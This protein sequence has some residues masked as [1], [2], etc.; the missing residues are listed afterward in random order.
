MS[1]A[2]SSSSIALPSPVAVTDRGCGRKIEEMFDLKL[3]DRV[4]SSLGESLAANQPL[5]FKVDGVKG[6]RFATHCFIHSKSVIGMG[7]VKK[8]TVAYDVKNNRLTS[9]VRMKLGKSA[10]T[11]KIIGKIVQKERNMMHLNPTGHPGIVQTYAIFQSKHKIDIYQELF[12][13]DLLTAIDN[14]QQT[15]DAICRVSEGVLKGLHFLHQRQYLHKDLKSENVFVNVGEDG[16][17][18]RAAIADWDTVAAVCQIVEVTRPCGTF[19]YLSPEMLQ[20]ILI[21]SNR[22]YWERMVGKKV[23]VWGFGCILFQ[24]LSRSSLPWTNEIDYQ[25]NPSWAIQ[26]SGMMMVYLNDLKEPPEQ[27]FLRKYD[28]EYMRFLP[29]VRRCLALAPDQ[30]P[31]VTQLFTDFGFS[32]PLPTLSFGNNL[33]DTERQLDIVVAPTVSTMQGLKTPPRIKRRHDDAATPL[34]G[35]R[36]PPIE[37]GLKTPPSRDQRSAQEPPHSPNKPS[38]IAFPSSL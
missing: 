35:K 11:D 19:E 22:V 14:H 32:R 9:R 2:S 17:I 15:A 4:L 29:I 10:V 3:I 18:S 37:E 36:T 21:S 38:V 25:N 1:V 16:L 8:I 24:M 31:A 7:Q 33:F 5:Y 12:D 27:L 34:E 6:A 23:D 28:P 13:C 20:R 26:Q 30:R